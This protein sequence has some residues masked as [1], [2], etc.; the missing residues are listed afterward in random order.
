[1]EQTTTTEELIYSPYLAMLEGR[2][3]DS[4]KTFFEHFAS[5]PEVVREIITSPGTAEKI[6]ALIQLN[7]IPKEYGIAIAKIVALVAMNE[8]P[9][10]SID[11]L[12]IKLNLAQE[13][14]TSIAAELVKILEPVIA[15]RARES[16]PKSMPELPPLTTKIPPRN[17]I[18]LRR[19]KPNA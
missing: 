14:A 15:E 3:V 5:Q 17:I 13:Q 2:D 11:Q 1:M 7:V 18:D 12:L 16:A 6:S 4:Q 8:V 19:Q 10:S 9:I